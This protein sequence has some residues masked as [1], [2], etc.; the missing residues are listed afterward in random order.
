MK[1][2]R[3]TSSATHKLSQRW[4]LLLL[5]LHTAVSHAVVQFEAVPGV[6]IK[7]GVRAGFAAV[8]MLNANL[9]L[10]QVDFLTR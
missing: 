3:R 10:G 2:P 7:A 4:L 6:D 1:P 9:G 5:V 8:T